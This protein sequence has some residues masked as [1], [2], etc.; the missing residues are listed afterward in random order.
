MAITKIQSES[1][2][3]ADDYAFTGT[4]TGA[5]EANDGSFFAY[6]GS[7][8]SISGQTTTTIQFNN[9]VFDVDSGFDAA[10]YR[11]TIPTGKGGKWFFQASIFWEPANASNQYGD[12]N[13][14]KNG[15]N[16]FQSRQA[17]SGNKQ[18]RDVFYSIGIG[19]FSAGDNID[20]R[21]WSSNGNSTD[22]NNKL[23][24]FT[25]FRISS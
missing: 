25:G 19:S 14:V 8:Q 24:Y 11:Y 9:T 4:I 15:T 12:I 16:L 23:T 5:G 13:I 2:N 1:L 21:V 10:N 17:V 20:V 7:N 3:L 18:R 22:A 6:Q